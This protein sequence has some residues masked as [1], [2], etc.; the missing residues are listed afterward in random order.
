MSDHKKLYNLQKWRKSSVSFRYNNPLCMECSRQGR[1]K[2]SEVV[3][4]IIDH[5]GDLSLFW[6]KDN[7]QSLCKECHSVKTYKENPKYIELKKAPTTIVCGSIGS[8]PHE[9]VQSII[10]PN[11][12]VIDFDRIYQ[13]ISGCDRYVKPKNLFPYVYKVHNFIQQIF[14]Q[15]TT[16]NHI[17]IT[18]FSGDHAKIQALQDRFEGST[19][20]ILLKD[21]ETCYRNCNRSREMLNTKI[22]W[23]KLISSWHDD[24]NKF[25]PMEDWIIKG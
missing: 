6:D 10:K 15:E 13:S 23:M 24:F 4:H 18:L 25:E 7:W 11:E 8:G 22:N 20:L 5:K 21:V 19:V 12:V 3:D 16:I 9:Y 17:Y 14:S 2:P 1:V